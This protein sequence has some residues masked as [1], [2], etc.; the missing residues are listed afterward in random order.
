[1]FGVHELRRPPLFT[2]ITKTTDEPQT[3]TDESQMS[4]RRLHTNH[5]QRCFEY[6]YNGFTFTGYG[7]PGYGFPNAPMKSWFL[8]KEGK[9]GI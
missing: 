4:H 8:L 9:S 7:F 3:T 5:S 6:I 2:I 1:M